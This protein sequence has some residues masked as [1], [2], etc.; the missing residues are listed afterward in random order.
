MPPCPGRDIMPSGR[1]RLLT[2]PSFHPRAHLPFLFLLFLL[3]LI[4]VTCIYSFRPPAFC[5]S[6]SASLLLAWHPHL[7]HPGQKLASKCP[8]NPCL[9][10]GAES[11]S[12]RPGRDFCGTPCHLF[13]SLL[14]RAFFITSWDMTCRGCVVGMTVII[15]SN[16]KEST[17]PFLP[18]HRRF[19]LFNHLG[20]SSPFLTLII[21][22]GKKNS[23][24]AHGTLIS[25]Q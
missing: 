25:L 20:P 8:P 22:T 17:F 4:T 18:E 13:T 3:W 14:I 21:V 2:C 1:L 5:P 10:R 11:V 7:H 24:V 19:F 12:R 9:V 16:L 15:A 6:S 23:T